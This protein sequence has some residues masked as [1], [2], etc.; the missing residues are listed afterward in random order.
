MLAWVLLQIHNHHVM[1]Q[2]FAGVRTSI[3]NGTF[4]ADAEKFSKTYEAA[5]PTSQGKGP[6]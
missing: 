6:R 2:F 1:D 3:A 4:E 5:M